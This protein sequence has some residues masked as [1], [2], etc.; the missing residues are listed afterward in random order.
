[1]VFTSFKFLVFL[2]LCV[3]VYFISPVKI[4]GYVLL[5][6]SI[7][8]YCIAGVKYLPFILGSTL[9]S[10][11]AAYYISDRYDK[12]KLELRGVE[13]LAI[14]A[15]LR[16]KCQRKC[17]IFMI[18]SL[19]VL[20]GVLCY[21][22]FAGM[23]YELFMPLI[24][25]TGEW[26]SLNI[27]VPLGISYYTFSTV[28]YVL[29]I[30]WERYSAEK[31]I[32]AYALYV[33]YFPHILQGPIAR[34]NRLGTQL[35]AEHRFD[36]KRVTFGAQLILWGFFQKLVIADR[37][38]IFVKS[39]YDS[40][41]DKSGP[42]L[43]IATL[44]YAVQIY[45]DFAGC[46]DIAKGI[47]QIFGIN[48]EDNFRQPYFSQ[49]VAEF[50]R[51]WHITLG[52]WFKDYLCMPVA[53]SGWVKKLSQKARKKWGKLAGKNTVTLISLAAVW[54]CT[55]V[56]HGTGA[57]YILWG[58][59]QGGIIAISTL[60]EPQ[61]KKWKKVCHIHDTGKAWQL[62]RILRTFVLTGIIPRVITRSPSLHGAAV[63]FKRMLTQI[64]FGILTDGSLFEYGLDRYDFFMALIAI[65][66][67]FFVSLAKERG[68]SIR[69]SIAGRSLPVRWM[70]YYLAFMSVLILGI[71]GPGYE[72]SSFVY[73]GF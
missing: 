42:V 8:F 44:F 38:G 1:M 60:L 63:I 49:S 35:W 71:Y 4:R 68:V 10:Y 66:V 67:L 54:F 21:T 58:F 34:F 46:V 56:W 6:F 11:A 9:L 69:E 3:G 20:I 18:I 36:Y 61:Y 17:R 29:D 19:L 59:W 39:V 45:T 14:Q 37:A 22:K 7:I 30:Y 23:I 32:F 72:A 48:L 28:G 47:S 64:D 5:I 26:S 16:E 33:M 70:I 57:N 50:W 24:S 51:R 41:E 13:D 73:M 55:G 40:Y 31:N 27:I 2:V 65:A 25:N 62:F 43:F 52:A 15:E 53:V 12:L